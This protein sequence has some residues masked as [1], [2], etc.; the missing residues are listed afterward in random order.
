MERECNFLG[1]Q[2]NGFRP[3][4]LDCGVTYRPEIIGG[5]M[6]PY[7]LGVLLLMLSACGEQSKNAGVKME[8]AVWRADAAHL[9]N[10]RQFLQANFKGFHR[11]FY[12]YDRGEKAVY[13]LGEGIT[14]LTFTAVPHAEME[15]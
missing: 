5:L 11:H 8:A 3:V 14:G 10:P 2:E 9:S 15:V 1:G 12:F 7:L 4:E 6:R 13:L